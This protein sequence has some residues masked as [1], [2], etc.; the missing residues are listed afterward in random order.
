MAALLP[1]RTVS[2]IKARSNIVGKSLSDFTPPRPFTAEEEVKLLDLKEK[3]YKWKDIALAL[4]RHRPAVRAHY[5][6]YLSF[7]LRSG[8]VTRP[9]TPVEDEQIR[10]LR[11]EKMAFSDIARKLQRIPQAVRDRYSVVTPESERTAVPVPLAWSDA[12]FE[13]CRTLR[14][15]GLS[16]KMIAKALGRSELGVYNKFHR[17]RREDEIG[18]QD[19]KERRRWI[20][21]DVQYL[22][23]AVAKGTTK[24][25]IAKE[26]D[27]TLQ[28]VENKIERLPETSRTSRER[29]K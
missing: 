16:V 13:Q 29:P 9:F 15:A 17:M 4:G 24:V 10:R 5:Y 20:E 22:T 23:H 18:K 7:G 27:R 26:L 6:Q 14:A 12:E 28:S 25:E 3:G 21:K 11:N 1:H 2:A 19:S 8:S